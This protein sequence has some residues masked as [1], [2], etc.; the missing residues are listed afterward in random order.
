MIG[1]L[2]LLPLFASSIQDD[3]VTFSFA[4]FGCNRV[5]KADW[6]IATNPSSANLPQLRQSFQDISNISPMPKVLFMTGDLVLGYGNDKG[7]ECRKQLDA[8]ISEY[9]S[10]PLSGKITM[11]PIS[12]NHE[13]NR[14]V[15]DEKLAS[16]Y[17][18]SMWNDWLKVNSLMPSIANGPTAGGPD[19]ISDDQSKLNFSF[20]QGNIHFVCLNTDTRTTDERIGFVPANW[21]KNDIDAATKA[22]KTIFL[23]GHRNVVDGITAA[24]DA[25]IEPK[26]GGELIKAMQSSPNVL[27][28][29][30]AHVHA[31]D[32]SK[33]NGVMP[34]QVIAG[35]GGSKLEKDW[36]PEGGKTYGFAVIE[37]HQSGTVNLVPYFRPAKD[38]A[39]EPAK[40]A[41]PILLGKM[42]G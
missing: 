23:L 4:F 26:S 16:S 40:P 32:V 28:Y 9:K 34:W 14:K 33:I 37:V 21:A 8:W 22:G 42:K 18:T 15:K 35:N 25:P 3:P 2:S 19:Q 24:G 17:T 38:D 27:G 11:V 6:D 12:G 39:V 7:E 20:D 29:L 41:T 5:D 31:W 36:K 10:S 13:M 1:L 30:C